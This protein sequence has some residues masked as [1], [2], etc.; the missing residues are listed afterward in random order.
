MV[1]APR[2]VAIFTIIRLWQLVEERHSKQFMQHHGKAHSFGPIYHFISLFA[3]LAIL[4]F[5]AP[6]LLQV[7]PARAAADN[8]WDAQWDYLLPL[9]IRANGAP[10]TNKPAEIALNFTQLLTGLGASGPFDPNSLRVIEVDGSNNVLDDAV[11]FQFDPSAGYDAAVNAT[12]TLVLLLNGSTPAN[13]ARSYHVYFDVAGKG[14]SAPT[15]PAQLTLTDDIFDED[16]LSYRIE[17]ARGTYYY[18]KQGAGFSSLVD[19]NGNDWL[20]YQPTGGAGGNFRGVPNMIHPEGKFHPGDTS[21][22]STILTQGPLKITIQ[23]TTTDDKWAA[24]W[25]FFPEYVRMTLLKAD[26]AYW[27][28]YEGTPGGTLD[29]E[30]DLV[31]RSDGTAT[32]AGVS[33]AGDLAGPEWVYFAD[34]L[35]NRA[36]FA[37]NHSNDNQIDSYYPMTQAAG[38]MTVFGF[39]RQGTNKFL[40]ATPTQFT[41]GLMNTIQFNQG[42]RMINNAYLELSIQLGSAMEQPV[43]PPTATPT[44]TPLPTAT[45]TETATPTPTFTA[46]ATA[47]PKPTET[48]TATF[49]PT[50]S[51][52]ATALPTEAATATVTPATAATETATAIPSPTAAVTLSP[53]ATADATLTPTATA[54]AAATPVA[55]THVNNFTAARTA[56]GVSLQWQTSSEGQSAGFYLY[57]AESSNATRFSPVSPLLP[58]RGAAGG[59]YQ[60]IDETVAAGQEYR[61]LLV[62]EKLDG[63]RI[64]Y[65]ALVII[66]GTGT[67]ET[68]RLLLPLVTN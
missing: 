21:A 38:S 36:F 41:I 23:S 48:A 68:H 4:A 22:T 57:R 53:T 51:A 52:T 18:Q 3:L 24:Q 10:R 7:H 26:H 32:P 50:A 1:K 64:D 37:V 15:F 60:F 66:I 30:T 28:L 6:P 9:T 39:G 63:S 46:T 2:A 49:T 58:S 20:S 5:H 40:T 44:T 12:G 62:E 11:P 13:G 8:W 42:R 34:P 29:L 17:T 56:I 31:V 59:T 55:E 43:V 54:T 35:V 47:T 14:F 67:E 25:E 33:W 16:Q 27:F 61:Y 65:E 45:P 19:Q